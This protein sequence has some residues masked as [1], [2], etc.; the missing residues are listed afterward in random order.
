MAASFTIAAHNNRFTP[1]DARAVTVESVK[2]YRSGMA[3]FAA[4]RTLDIWY[5][6]WTEHDMQ[7]A[8]RAV[9][10]ASAAARNR[11]KARPVRRREEEETGHLEGR[12]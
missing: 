9:K 10:E 11:A 1:A 4:T 12:Q 5:A 8:M 2:A 6:H 7:D 3:E